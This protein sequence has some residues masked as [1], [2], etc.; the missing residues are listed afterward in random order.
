MRNKVMAESSMVD[1]SLC[2]VFLV[3]CE[4]RLG[5]REKEEEW[6]AVLEEEFVM[7]R[8][9]DAGYLEC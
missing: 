4:V 3:L 5:W 2:S 7:Q 8:L 6:F 1:D 9:N